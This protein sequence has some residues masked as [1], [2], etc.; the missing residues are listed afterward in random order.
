MIKFYKF[1]I[2]EALME[3]PRTLPIIYPHSPSNVSKRGVSPFALI[4]S[5]HG[6]PGH[7]ERSINQ[8]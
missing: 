3:A 7:K 5:E 4:S 2:M 6:I 1:N 8:L